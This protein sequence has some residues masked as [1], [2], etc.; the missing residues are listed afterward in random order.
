MI[1][2]KMYDQYGVPNFQRSKKLILKCT[3]QELSKFLS[4]DAQVCETIW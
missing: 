1:V 4:E 2:D 3:I